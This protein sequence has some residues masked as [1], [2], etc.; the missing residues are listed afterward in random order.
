MMNLFKGEV[1]LC[2]LDP[3]ERDEDL[4]KD[5]TIVM[6]SFYRPLEGIFTSLTE[7]YVDSTVNRGSE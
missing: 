2:Y 6:E 4:S 5:D 7:A 1:I 3:L